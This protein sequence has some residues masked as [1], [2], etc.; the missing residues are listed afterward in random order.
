MS[1][2]SCFIVMVYWLCVGP[3]FIA[4]LYVRFMHWNKT[5]LFGF[6]F[7]YTIDI[8]NRY[9]QWHEPRWHYTLTVL[10]YGSIGHDLAYWSVKRMQLV[11]LN[12]V[13]IKF[14]GVETSWSNYFKDVYWLSIKRWIRDISTNGAS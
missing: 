9:S 1:I 5:G 13:Q 7:R 3:L 10:V 11:S 2:S 12:Q 8:V 14:G 4:S 6:Y